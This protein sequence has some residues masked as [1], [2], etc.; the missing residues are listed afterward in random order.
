MIL[1]VDDDPILRTVTSQVLSHSGYETKAVDGA[2]AALAI[3]H[4]TEP[5]L[6]LCD[7]MMPGADGFEFRKQY[8]SRY[9]DRRTP[10]VYL[11][12]RED[13]EFQVESLESGVDDYLVKPVSPAVLVARVRRYL[14]RH[15]R[16][17]TAFTGELSTF[18]F[19]RLMQFCERQGFTGHVDV[20]APTFSTSVSFHKGVVD[21]LDDELLDR[22]LAATE[23]TFTIRPAAIDFSELPKAGQVTARGRLSSLALRGGLVDI[24]TTV[25]EGRIES[26]V[27]L[28][29]K[30]LQHRTFPLVA[31][32]TPEAE[33]A[34]IASAHAD[35]EAAVRQQLT[36]FISPASSELSADR[37]TRLYDTGFEHFAARR[38]DEAVKAWEAALALQPEHAA[39]KVNLEVARR[40]RNRVHQRS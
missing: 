33:T 32:L 12:A 11:T 10:F 24:E 1:I 25:R 22:L 16:E 36:A 27:T 39:L 35:T 21:A 23:G 38:Y 40:R 3:V 26:R 18:D 6:I 30:A 7:V 19:V 14:A 8:L 31:G 5:D 34:R 29:G 9:P 2:D 37:F 17:Q 13:P 4:A 15:R 28:N 20:K